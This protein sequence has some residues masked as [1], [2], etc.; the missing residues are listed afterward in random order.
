MKII[1]FA[2]PT[3][4]EQE[5]KTIL[6]MVTVRP[7]AKQGDILKEKASNP[8]IILLI[9]GTFEQHPAVWHKEI[10]DAMKSNVAV[11]GCSSMGALRASELSVYGMIGVGEIFQQFDSGK[12]EDDDE[13]TL[14][15][16]DSQYGYAHISEALV[17]IRH[18]LHECV[19]KNLISENIAI[20]IE[21]ELKATWYPNR[22]YT[23]MFEIAAKHLSETALKSF[24]DYVNQITSLKK[25]DALTALKLVKDVQEKRST[26]AP[27]PE[28]D[29][30]FTDAWQMMLDEFVS[31][32][33]QSLYS[34]DTLLKS[35]TLLAGC[36]PH[37]LNRFLA[38][39]L[40]PNVSKDDTFPTMLKIATTWDCSS[41]GKPDFNKLGGVLDELGITPNEFIAFIERETTL[42]MLKAKLAN[43]T[44][45]AIDEVLSTGE[46]EKLR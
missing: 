34:N 1:V 36:Q 9:D 38:S 13:V 28:F 37:I 21:A 39:K 14:L 35:G 24:T 45:F 32:K 17:D 31:E 30:S 11:I 5:I 12:L 19:V 7:P 4:S 46:L 23:L 8:D 26:F 25:L 27:P 3:I 44:S 16:T 42:D 10:L 22:T 18:A 6:P 20:L 29:F 43:Q 41:A 33:T 40:M 2:G 15:H